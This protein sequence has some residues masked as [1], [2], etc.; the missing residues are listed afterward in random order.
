MTVRTVEQLARVVARSYRHIAYGLCICNVRS[1]S[2][3]IYY[4]YS[5]ALHVNN[6]MLQRSPCFCSI[7]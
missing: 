6:N 2:V 5:V 3:Y 1:L 4:I 7:S